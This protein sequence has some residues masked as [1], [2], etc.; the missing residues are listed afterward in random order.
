MCAIRHTHT[1]RLS[2]QI[3]FCFPPTC[4]SVWP[5]RF[6][7]PRVIH[8]SFCFSPNSQSPIIHQSSTAMRASEVPLTT[9]LD[10]WVESRTK[11]VSLRARARACGWKAQAILYETRRVTSGGAHAVT[12]GSIS[13]GRR[14]VAR[15]VVWVVWEGVARLS[16]A[17][18]DCCGTVR[19]YDIK[20]FIYLRVT[21]ICAARII[22]SVCRLSNAVR[23]SDTGARNVI[24]LCQ[25]SQTTHRCNP[26]PPITNPS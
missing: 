2:P 23:S 7:A 6:H 10:P 9:S 21:H 16:Q 17:I 13:N 5:I 24:Q 8:L 14:R 26:A 1:Q 12:K 11:D 4:D 3:S 25:T 15:C 19:S 18:P 22:R 20:T